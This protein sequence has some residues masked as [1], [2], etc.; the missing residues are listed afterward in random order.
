MA[1][2]VVSTG[3]HKARAFCEECQDGRNGGA[4]SVRKWAVQHNLEEHPNG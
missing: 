2:E 1:A 3:P 4:A